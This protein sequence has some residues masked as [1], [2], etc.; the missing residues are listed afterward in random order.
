MYKF[1]SRKGFIPSI[2]LQQK[3][4]NSCNSVQCCNYRTGYTRVSF[5][6]V[7]A[8]FILSLD[9]LYFS[10]LYI[11]IGFI[12][13]SEEYVPLSMILILNWARA[14]LARNLPYTSYG[15][16]QKCLTLKCNFPEVTERCQQGIRVLVKEERINPNLISTIHGYL[17]CDLFELLW[18]L[19]DLENSQK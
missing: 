8:I 3:R 12:S 4:T 5:E 11:G 10:R 16:F 13:D 17:N 7:E 19:S 2:G 14:S 18:I 15:L 1:R 9:F 6:I